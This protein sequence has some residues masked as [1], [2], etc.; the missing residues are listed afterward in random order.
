ME[1]EHKI[2][3]IFVCTDGSMLGANFGLLSAASFHQETRERS[4]GVKLQA[5]QSLVAAPP[6]PTSRPI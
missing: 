4:K 5:E 1:E 3:M 6:G 2:G